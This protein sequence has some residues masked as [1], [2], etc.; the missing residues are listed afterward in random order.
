MSYAKS[1]G[2]SSS[3]HFQSPGEEPGCDT[4]PGLPLLRIREESARLRRP[5]FPALISPKEVVLT[6]IGP[7]GLSAFDGVG[8]AIIRYTEE[9]KL[10]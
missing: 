3:S 4:A 7:N 2:T 1:Q 8:Y 6:G 9:S 10:C 5:V